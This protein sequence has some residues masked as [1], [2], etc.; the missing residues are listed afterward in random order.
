MKRLP[1]VGII[2][3]I[4]CIYVINTH[5]M[6]TIQGNIESIPIPKKDISFTIIDNIGTLTSV[7]HGSIDGKDYIS[8][9]NGLTLNVIPLDNIESID[10]TKT[11]KAPASILEKL[12][13]N[14]V[15]ATVHLKNGGI[16]TILMDGSLLCYGKTPYGYVR[17][18]L[19]LIDRIQD[20]KLLKKQK[21]I[22]ISNHK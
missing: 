5:A 7:E 13:N 20:I 15:V 10:F 21:E 2:L 11:T 17:I 8:G 6:G 4:L 14:P 1:F 9:Y 19:S 12:D 18:K 3:G 22:P 16:L